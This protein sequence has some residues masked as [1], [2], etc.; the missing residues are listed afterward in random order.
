MDKAGTKGQ[1]GGFGPKTDC[2]DP[3][4]GPYHLPLGFLCAHKKHD[5]IKSV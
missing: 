1:D 5:K 3:L 4:N 2:W